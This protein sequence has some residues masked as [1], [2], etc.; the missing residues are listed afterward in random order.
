MGWTC[1]YKP[2][3]LSM[4]EFF[5]R[6]GA[7]TW[8]ADSPNKYRVLDSGT[9]AR[10]VFYAAVERIDP[11]GTRDVFAV[12]FLLR[13]TTGHYNLCYKDMDET[14]GPLEARCP[15][16]ILDLLTPTDNEYANQWRHDCRQYHAK[17]KKTKTLKEGQV[18]QYG[19]KSYKLLRSLGR[20]G[21]EVQLVTSPFTAYRMKTSQLVQC[22][23]IS[24]EV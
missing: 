14:M 16:R 7:L 20:R 23:L 4:L 24:T 11:E 6:E 1:T 19:G 10:T 3:D 17:R 21:W 18:L 15:E 12:I 8:S 2:S 13:W 9:V 5:Q 22:D